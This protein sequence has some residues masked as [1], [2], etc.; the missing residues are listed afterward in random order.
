MMQEGFAILV[1]KHA[2]IL[3]QTVLLDIHKKQMNLLGII[4]LKLW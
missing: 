3:N 4:L 1:G 2:K